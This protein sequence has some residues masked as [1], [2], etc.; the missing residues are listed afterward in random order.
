MDTLN[1]QLCNNISHFSSIARSLL[2]QYFEKR[3]INFDGICGRI[4]GT[5]FRC[6]P[7]NL[8]HQ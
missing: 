5:F 8:N 2:T 7:Q 4:H 3:Y 1:P 6:Q